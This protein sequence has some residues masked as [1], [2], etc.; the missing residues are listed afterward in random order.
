MCSVYPAD[1]TKQIAVI[2]C[3][4]KKYPPEMKCTNEIIA[5]EKL[6]C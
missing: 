4:S 2:I 1:C 3:A 6:S 5:D